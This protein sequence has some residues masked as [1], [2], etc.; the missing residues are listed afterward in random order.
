M[1]GYLQRGH[2]TGILIPSQQWVLAILS[3]R[4]F[5]VSPTFQIILVGHNSRKLASNG[6]IHALHD[7]KICWEE[8]IEVALVNLEM[9]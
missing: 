8:N 3:F 2:D 7:V 9:V 1:I 6:A 5:Y 4:L